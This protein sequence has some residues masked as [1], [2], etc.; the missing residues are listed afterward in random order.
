MDAYFSLI[1]L[2]L[3][4]FNFPK[5]KNVLKKNYSPIDSKS[6]ELKSPPLEFYKITE[7]VLKREN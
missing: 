2:S 7:K 3:N 1:V 5:L 6:Q 4:I